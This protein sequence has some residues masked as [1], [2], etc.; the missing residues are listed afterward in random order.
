ME[1]HDVLVVGAGNAGI[2]LVARLL[3]DGTRDVALLDDSPVHRYRPLLNYVGSG[4][5][6]MRHL[7][8][9]L[10]TVV[11]DGCAWIREGAVAV[12]AT[13]STVTTT[14]GRTLSWGTLVLCPGL[15]EDWD[16]TPGLSAA[17]DAGWACSTFVPEA[18]PRVWPAL[19]ALRGGSVVFSV[20][21]EP[22]P[23]AATALK[24]LF[25]AC[26]SW[27]RAGVL[28]DL[29]VRLVLPGGTAVGLP[30]ADER[31][32]RALASY[33]VEVLRGARVTAVDPAARALTVTTAEG[34]RG[35][36][37]LDVAHVVPHYRGHRWLERS[38]LTAAGSAGLV[39][40]DPGTLRHR[41]HDRVWSLGD[42]ADLRIRPSGGA[43][44]PQVGV[45]AHN[46]AAVASGAP[47]HRYDGYTVMP[48]TLGRSELMLV[49][50]DRDRHPAPSVP[51][52]DLTRPRRLTWLVDRY[53]LPQVYVHRIL[54]GRV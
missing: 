1:H 11:P 4:E 38:G 21:P 40:V 14:T 12:D 5:A 44:R 9:P 17:Y 18:A 52:V 23:C 6:A 49:E 54:R 13:A 42:A 25:M 45:L 8:R 31:V 3:R 30:R 7:E 37:G 41:R 51:L 46:L 32:E 34:T 50:M 29:H 24:P 35:L 39:D 28:D 10:A 19:R 2:S 47:L 22:A 26:D 43:L 33:G 27:R 20:P 53:V 15:D 16:A 36:D 48:I